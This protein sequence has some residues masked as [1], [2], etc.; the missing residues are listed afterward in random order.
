LI[1]EWVH[2]LLTLPNGREIELDR[3]KPGT[4]IDPEGI[5][6][7]CSLIRIE[8]GS[9][10]LQEPKPGDLG[11]LGY[12]VWRQIRENLQDPGQDPDSLMPIF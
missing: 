11:K 12:E 10:T 9:P 1:D 7:I 4:N 3:R 5:K 2:L 6:A 8:A